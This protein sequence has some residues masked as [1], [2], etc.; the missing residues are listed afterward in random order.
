MITGVQWYK[1]P[2]YYGRPKTV[3]GHFRTWVK[4]GLFDSILLK[5]I[6]IVV[7]TL[8]VPNS[9][10]S[11]TSSVKAPFAKFGGKNPTVRAKNGVKKAL[12]SIGIELSCRF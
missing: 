1:L 4:S 10:F 6:M 2:D 9:F 12:L 11:D 7:K 3:H 8:G 5:S